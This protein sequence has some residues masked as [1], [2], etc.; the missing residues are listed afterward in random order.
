MG[1]CHYK[2]QK[3]IIEVSPLGFS[4]NTSIIEVE[5]QQAT[6]KTT[7]PMSWQNLCS[8]QTSFPPIVA[9]VHFNLW[10]KDILV[11]M[12]VLLTMDDHVFFDNVIQE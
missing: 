11:D 4:P 3:K 5:I 2:S 8:I 9:N 1:R 10:G 7:W 12:G 6:K